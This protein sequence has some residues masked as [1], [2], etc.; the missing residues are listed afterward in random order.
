MLAE[1]DRARPATTGRFRGVL[2]YYDART[3]STVNE[4]E[5]EHGAV[6]IHRVAHWID[7]WLTSRVSPWGHPP[8]SRAPDSNLA[9]GID[10]RAAAK[11]QEEKGEGDTA[12]HE[13]ALRGIAD[14]HDI[15]RLSDRFI[16]RSSVPLGRRSTPW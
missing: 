4:K 11:E 6:H 12:H 9:T 15:R 8:W 2:H 7:T 5:V 16:H 14:G 10:S 3:F 1:D 13:R